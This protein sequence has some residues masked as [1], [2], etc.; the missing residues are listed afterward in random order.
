ML[1]LWAGFAAGSSPRRGVEEPEEEQQ[2][3]DPD[4]VPIEQHLPKHPRDNAQ[5]LSR[6]GSREHQQHQAAED[7]GVGRGP[8]RST[9]P[10]VL[11]AVTSS[12]D[13]SLVSLLLSAAR[14]YD[15]RQRCGTALQR[16]RGLRWRIAASWR[17]HTA[18]ADVEV[19]AI[20]P[21]AE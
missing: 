2:D 3:G 16:G 19:T 14:G 21:P 12:I 18:L 7:L 13:T 6:V 1:S 9:P 8:P 11:V 10:E 17:V 4:D 15:R 20:G 5:E